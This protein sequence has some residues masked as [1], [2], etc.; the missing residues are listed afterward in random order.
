[1]F[2]ITLIVLAVLAILGST[3]FFVLGTWAAVNATRAI[4]RVKY[5]YPGQTGYAGM[6]IFGLYFLSLWALA[7]SA[8]IALGTYWLFRLYL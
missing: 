2:E 3:L 5:L 1:M 8:G 7:C 4:G 6:G